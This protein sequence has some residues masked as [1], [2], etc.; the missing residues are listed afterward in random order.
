[1]YSTT[2][3][4]KATSAARQSARGDRGAALLAALCFATVMAIAL[5]S[6]LMVCYRSLAMSTRAM[7]STRSAEIAELG[8][9]DALWSLNNSTW[10]GWTINGTTATKTIT[11]FTFDNSATGS[12]SITITNYDGTTGTRNV[13]VTAST[14]LSDGS[15]VRRTL[16][17]TSAEAPLMTNAVAATTGLVKFTAATTSGIIDSYDSTAGAYVAASAGYSAVVAA[18]S[19]STSAS[20][21]QLTNA[22]VKGY[23]ATVS[24]GPSYSTSAKIFGPTTPG[25]TRIDNARISTSPYQPVFDI[26]SISGA[27]TTLNNPV[28]DTI[29]TI[30]TSGASSASIYYNSGLNMV[31]ATKIIVDGPVKLVV[32]GNMYIGLSGGTPSIEVTANGTLEVFVSGDIAIYGNGINNLTTSPKKAVIYGSNSLTAPDMNT[33]T[34]FYGVIYTP[35][36][37]FK[38]WSNNAIYGSIVARNVTFSGTA[39]A[40]HYDTSLRSVTLAGITTP[41]AVSNWRDT[42]DAN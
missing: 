5:S 18:G 7:S 6:Y 26:K 19:T 37:D 38:V 23:V 35:T 27:G 22:Q 24:T 10:T 8:M 36:G 2:H 1:M 39:P 4:L 14:S 20:T 11:G 42:A 31:G 30:G 16:T 40:V 29:T 12:V 41:F 15:Q 32:S 25:T 17:A 3:S 28:T 13:T 21:V 33:T 9:E 34:P